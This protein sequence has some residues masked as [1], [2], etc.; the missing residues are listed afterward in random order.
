M[1]LS[2]LIKVIDYWKEYYNIRNEDPDVVIQIDSKKIAKAY[3][4][5]KLLNELDLLNDSCDRNSSER[6]NPYLVLFTCEE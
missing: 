1:K 2:E 3:K 5:G 6:D 4:K